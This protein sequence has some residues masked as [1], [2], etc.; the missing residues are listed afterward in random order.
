[1]PTTLTPSR[2]GIPLQHSSTTRRPRVAT[3]Q[4]R[5]DVDAADLS[6]VQERSARLERTDSTATTRTLRKPRSHSRFASLG[7]IKSRPSILQRA[8]GDSTEYT[9]APETRSVSAAQLPI[10]DIPAPKKAFES[11]ARPESIRHSSNSS[12]STLQE[13]DNLS[14]YSEKDLDSPK[15]TFWLASGLDRDDRQLLSRGDF[16][17]QRF[18]A[19]RP[20]KMHQTSSRLLRMTEDDRPFTR[21]SQSFE[22]CNDHP[23]NRQDVVTCR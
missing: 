19:P 7:R 18:V 9:A 16:D 11:P 10:K 15:A 2:P 4:A 21:V 3:S 6:T 17:N 1:M 12:D 22:S 8:F 13:K 20:S 5:P 23:H 14:L